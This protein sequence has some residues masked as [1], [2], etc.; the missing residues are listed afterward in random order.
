M[1]FTWNCNVHNYDFWLYVND[2]KFVDLEEH[3]ATEAV[4]KEIPVKP[5]PE[6]EVASTT[7]VKETEEQPNLEELSCGINETINE[8]GR[9]CEPDCVTVSK[10]LL[11][12]TVAKA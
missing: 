12:K 1:Q 5:I 7:T 2:G 3:W 6:I 11:Y 10:F 4:T 8:C 9:I